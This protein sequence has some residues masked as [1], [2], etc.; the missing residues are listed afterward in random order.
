MIIKRSILEF[1][2]AIG[3]Q[4]EIPSC[5]TAENSMMQQDRNSKN[6]K[7]AI[8]NLLNSLSNIQ[9]DNAGGVRKLHFENFFDCY[10]IKPSEYPFLDDFV[11]RQVL[12]SLPIEFEQLKMTYTVLR[13]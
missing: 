3:I 8:T 12:N 10:Q 13:E 2:D 5:D 1:L 9:H 11:V 6:L 4:L 7:S